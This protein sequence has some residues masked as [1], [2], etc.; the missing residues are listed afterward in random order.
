MITK[1]C[2]LRKNS[3]TDGSAALNTVRNLPYIKLKICAM[4][5]IIRVLNAIGKIFCFIV[6]RV[7]E[8][9]KRGVLTVK[10]F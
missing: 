2:T 1:P 7:A 3:F 4:V 6:Q 5:V 10:T 9:N 8:R